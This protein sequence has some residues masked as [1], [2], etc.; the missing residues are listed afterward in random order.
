MLSNLRTQRLIYQGCLRASQV[1]A[2]IAWISLLPVEAHSARALKLESE[3][4]A[5]A[6]AVG[7]SLQQAFEAAQEKTE[8]IPRAQ[9][10]VVQAEETKRQAL[11][12][13]LPRIVLRGTYSR[14]DIPE[15]LARRNS[16]AQSDTSSSNVAF[17]Q[18][19]F[20]GFGEF[21][22][23]RSADANYRAAARQKEA[24]RLSLFASV[25]QAYYAALAADTDVRNVGESLRLNG[26]REREV[27]ERARIGRS[28]ASE[29]LTA[30]AQ[31][32]TAVANLEA[33]KLVAAQA[34]EDF[35]FATGLP[36]DSPLADSGTG[37]SNAVAGL[38]PIEEYLRRLEDRPDVDAFKAQVEAAEES[39]NVARAGHYPTLDFTGNYYIARA[40]LFQDSKWDLGLSLSIPIY[41]GGVIDSQV[42][43]ALSIVRRATLALSQAKRSAARDVEVAYK[44]ARSGAS[45][46]VA[47]KALVDV[48][49]RN[50]REQS[51]DYRFGLS[52]N[53]DVLVALNA[54][55]DARRAFDRARFQTAAA[56]A[57]LETAS[58]RIP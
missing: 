58:G 14:Q 2:T 21:A 22:A 53:V 42:R 32:A 18:P 49:E 13:V 31:M 39:A 46:V 37:L 47:Y 11:G 23:L 26:A 25:A 9:E 34:R 3:F 29:L 41:V 54:L 10:G 5:P 43:Q 20:R 56:V 27:K 52:Q 50:F 15:S 4:K 6:P 19:L 24:A 16:I 12:A 28:R 17:T 44:A 1:V 7:L 33:A 57:S 38:A 51:K 8:T 40:G 36:A 30:Q 48:S 35:A 55:I 45:Q